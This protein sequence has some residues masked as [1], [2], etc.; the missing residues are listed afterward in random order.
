MRSLIAK[1]S[2]GAPQRHGAE[3]HYS[4][5]PELTETYA[6]GDWGVR[7]VGGC[8]GDRPRRRERA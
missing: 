5:T 6:A 4:G 7:I 1:A 2:A 8:C 3:I